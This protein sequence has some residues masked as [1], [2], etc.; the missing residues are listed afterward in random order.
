MEKRTPLKLTGQIIWIGDETTGTNQGTGEIWRRRSFIIE[1]EDNGY[2][3]TVGFQAWGLQAE[4][5]SRA[6]T[7]D[8]ATVYF[9]P[10]TR[11]NENKLYTELKAYGIN[12]KFAQS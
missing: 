2:K 3:N 5:I 8:T 10:I 7:G 9:T 1:I 11:V 6:R 12:F 4:N